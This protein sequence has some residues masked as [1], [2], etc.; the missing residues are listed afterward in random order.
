MFR[1]HQNRAEAGD[2]GS[3]AGLRKI[4]PGILWKKAHWELSQGQV[5][6]AFGGLVEDSLG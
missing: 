3:F 5:E 4:L 6:V 2:H 1:F